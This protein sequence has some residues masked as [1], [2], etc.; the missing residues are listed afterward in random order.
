MISVHFPV[1]MQQQLG[2]HEVSVCISLPWSFVQVY[3]F[4]CGT[5]FRNPWHLLIETEP[6]NLK[7]Y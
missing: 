4:W 6:K 2:E 5:I 1:E 7:L 3:N